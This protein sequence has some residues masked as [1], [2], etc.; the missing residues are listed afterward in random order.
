MFLH[1]NRIS[2]LADGFTKYT[3]TTK[4][5]SQGGSKS[6]SKNSLNTAGNGF[7]SDAALTLAKDSADIFFAP[8]GNLV[9]NLLIQESANALN[10]N[11]KDTL[12]LLLLENP[13]RFRSSLP[14][15]L[16]NFLPKGPIVEVE[17]F[18]NKSEREMQ[19][20]ALLQ[21]FSFPEAPPPNE[22]AG[23]IRNMGG[24]NA[25]ASSVEGMSNEEVAILWK[26]IRENVPIYGPRVAKL[27]SKFASALLEKVSENIDHVISTSEENTALPEQVVRNSAKGISAAARRSSDALKSS[28]Q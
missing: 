8:E 17:R 5:V 7:S 4:L 2:D 12:R 22:L 25:A 10:A 14:L 1:I 20:Q 26:S 3:T 9:Q 15:G 16:G 28:A 21:K 6:T 11:M 18:L 13:E 23:M 19:V 27:G 24:S